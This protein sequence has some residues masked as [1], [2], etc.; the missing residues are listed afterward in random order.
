MTDGNTYAINQHLNE[1]EDWDELQEVT[2]ELEQAEAK[3]EELETKLEDY[4]RLML[5]LTG[6]KIDLVSQLAGVKFKLAKAVGNLASVMS[7]YDR[8]R[9]D[10]YAVGLAPLDDA[11]ETARTTL[12]ELRGETDE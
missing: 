8:F 3:V 9:E 4:K 5:T 7:Q 10:E 11:I 6:D 2:A 12:A 1:R